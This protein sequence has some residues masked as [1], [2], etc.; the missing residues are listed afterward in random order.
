[1]PTSWWLAAQPV[2]SQ[3][4]LAEVGLGLDSNGQSPITEDEHA[5][6]VP[7]TWLGHDPTLSGHTW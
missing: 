4:A 6:I 2:T 5:T 7:A 1:M 3:H